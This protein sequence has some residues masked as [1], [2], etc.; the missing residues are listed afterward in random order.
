[1]KITYNEKLKAYM[2]EKK[3][4]FTKEEVEIITNALLTARFISKKDTRDIIGKLHRLTGFYRDKTITDI[5]RL[6]D[7][8]KIRNDDV[9]IKQ[10]ISLIREAISKDRKIQFNY[11]KYNTKK[12]LVI[13]KQ[14]CVV[15]PYEAVW[16]QDYYY[17]LGNYDGDRISHYRVDRMKEVKI[18]EDRRKNISEIIGAGKQFNVAEY[19]SRL[20]GMS[21][22]VEDVV[23][24]MFKKNCIGDVIDSLG[25]KV[26]I[27]DNGPE[28]F[29]LR[30]RVLINKKFVKWVLSFGDGAVVKEPVS[31]RQEIVETIKSQIEAY[32]IKNY[33]QEGL[34]KIINKA[35][36][37]ATTAHAKQKRKGTNIPY[38]FHPLEAGVI[39]SQIIYDED[40]VC[41]AILHDNKNPG[42][43]Q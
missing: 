28:Y 18:L 11:V 17:M 26:S 3:T 5:V 14:N 10:N 13:E 42:Q 1:M 34:N 12:S 38:I 25:D 37:L 27:Q 20:F 21:S 7:R 41:A 9:K 23:V 8:V 24:I 29:T 32:K 19:M 43:R 40:I 22:G 2:V 16:Y 30:A 39:S 35:I 33:N 36:V 31:L 4:A 6:D 15:S